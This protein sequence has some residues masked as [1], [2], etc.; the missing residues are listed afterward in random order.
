MDCAPIVGIDAGDVANGKSTLCDVIA[1]VATG[2]DAPKMTNPPSEEEAQKAWI[3]MLM[4]GAPVVCIEN[5]MKGDTIGGAVL[6]RI[7]TEKRFTGRILSVNINAD[8]PTNALILANGNNLTARADLASRM[9]KSRI[10]SG[11][12]HAGERTFKRDIRV[13]TREHRGEIIAAALTVMRAYV[14]AGKPKEFTSSRFTQWDN[15][16]RGSIIFCNQ[17]DPYLTSAEVDEN[18]P[19]R[20]D[21]GGLLDAFESCFHDEWAGSKEI[22]ARLTVNDDKARA[23]QGAL[24]GSTSDK[25]SI[26]AAIKA[27]IGK[28]VNDRRFRRRTRNHIVQ[29]QIENMERLV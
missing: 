12:E 9:I 24:Y 13:W 2:R 28:V 10:D 16:V 17:P 29:F 5:V 21:L 14:V 23:L 18:D 27:H 3:T 19:D 26:T 8:L 11:L 1:T 25:K 20:S 4:D 7:V 22:A 6:A 15:L